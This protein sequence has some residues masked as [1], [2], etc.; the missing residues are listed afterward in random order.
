MKS[1]ALYSLMLLVLFFAGGLNARSQN[2][3]KMVVGV[4]KFTSETDSPFVDAVSEKIVQIVSDTKRFT[5]VDRTSYAKVREELELQKSEAF[6]DSKNT[7]QQDVALAAEYM[8]IG[9]LIKM[10]IYSMKNPDGSVNGYKASAAFTLK[11]NNVE[12]GETTEAAHFQTEVS[13]QAAS[14]EQAVN[15][16]LA[17]IEKPVNEYFIQTFP[18]YAKILK[19]TEVKK[20]VAKTVLI[21]GGRNAGLKVGDKLAVEVTEMLDGKPY[22]DEIGSLAVEKL[23][24]DDFAECKV[25]KGGRELLSHF[26]ADNPIKCRLIVNLK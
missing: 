15:Q 7:V 19:V 18:V 20:D 23:S 13:P 5:V 2:N 17:S 24:G 6:L 1:K 22:P 4:A 12:T 3:D 25:T 14:K 11:V 26:S 8:I 10:N 16:A 9:H 21:N